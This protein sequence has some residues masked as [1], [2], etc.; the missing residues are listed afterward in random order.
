M[1]IFM[2]E[3][4]S[5]MLKLGMKIMGHIALS[6]GLSFNYFDNWF[7]KD[8]LSTL[9]LI[10]YSPRNC[11]LDI[12]QDSLSE[13][14]MKF[15]TPIHAD[16]TILTLLSTFNYPGLQVNVNGQYKSV[17]PSPNSI[18]INLGEM[19]SK[20]TNNKFKATLHRVLDIYIDRYS[21]PFFLE[22]NYL[23]KIP[24]TLVDRELHQ[25]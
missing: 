15:T 4:Y 24:S 12:K 21:S 6:M 7:A 19:F 18:V 20:M 8:T 13:E 3:H 14:E 5:R 23:A 16:S 10:H 11:N 22:P 9:R 1:E 2:N 25:G 17:R